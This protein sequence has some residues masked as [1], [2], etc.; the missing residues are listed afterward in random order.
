MTTRSELLDAAHDELLVRGWTQRTGIDT[1]TGGVCSVAAITYAWLLADDPCER[2]VKE[3][4]T[5]AL[6]AHVGRPVTL[7]N[8]DSERTFDE[9]LD[10]FR[11]TAKKLR[12]VGD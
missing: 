9:V 8:D 10:A 2:D 7:W 12:E 4:A 5:D 3:A 11:N 6:Q 1:K